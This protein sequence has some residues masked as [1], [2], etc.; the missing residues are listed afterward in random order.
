[1]SVAAWFDEND[2][3]ELGGDDARKGPISLHRQ[4]SITG[5]MIKVLFNLPALYGGG[6]E[7][8]VL[9]VMGNLD[10]ALFRADLFLMK[11]D[12]VYWNEV[13]QDVSV[14]C[15][16]DKLRLRNAFAAVVWRYCVVARSY[17]VLVGGLELESTY[18]AWLAGKIWN[19]P[20]VGWVHVALA[21][22]L[23]GQPRWHRR[24][25]AY[26]YPRLDKIVCQALGSV[27]SLR[28]VASFTSSQMR[29]MSYP[30]DLLGVQ[31]AGLSADPPWLVDSDKGP[32]V[33][34]CGRLNFQKG[35]DVLIKAHKLVRSAGLEHRL[36]I[37][38]EGPLRSELT[39]LIAQVGVSDSV[40]MPGFLQNPF[41][42]I[43]HASAFVLSSRFEGLPHVILE[44]LAL[45][46]PVVATDCQSGPAEILDNGRY[47]ILV[48][49]EDAEALA[50]ALRTIIQNKELRVRLGAAGRIRAAEYSPLRT[51]PQWEA[52]LTEVSI[53]PGEERQVATS[54]PAS[55]SRLPLP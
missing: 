2:G 54:S 8:G 50:K 44:A 25:V 53:S 21:E 28:E 47:G 41:P 29:V 48:P 16:T 10:K 38:G 45:G 30:F 49:T 40:M 32:V 12:G 1:V 11:R 4:C 3:G 34:A 52:L 7:R 15:G 18:L 42:A 35:F 31:R 5:T 26:V 24:A 6:A 43:R 51:A 20:V 33:V 13:P 22:Y 19:K 39:S 27:D 23:K 17:D 9:N 55:Q 46:T 36:C 37:L 14:F